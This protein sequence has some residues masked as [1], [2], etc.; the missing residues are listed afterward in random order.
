M[1]IEDII[2]FHEGEMAFH[3]AKAKQWAKCAAREAYSVDGKRFYMTLAR[4]RKQNAAVHR[5]A[6]DLLRKL[7]A[8]T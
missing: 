2:A 6:A 7:S 3:E 5:A 1:T 8:D 4:G